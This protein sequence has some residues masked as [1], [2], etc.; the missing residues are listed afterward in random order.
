[1]SPLLGLV[2][3]GYVWISTDINAKVGGFTWLLI[4]LVVLVVLKRRGRRVSAADLG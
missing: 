4:G 3:I 1:M 2:I